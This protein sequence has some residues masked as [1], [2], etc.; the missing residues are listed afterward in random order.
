VTPTWQNRAACI[1]HT[2]ELFFAPEHEYPRAKDRRIAQAKVI[3]GGCPVRAECLA[4]AEAHDEKHGIWGGLT[5]MERGAAQTRSKAKKTVSYVHG[6][7]G[8]AGGHRNR[9][10]DPCEVC[11]LA[12]NAYMLAYNKAKKAQRRAS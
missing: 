10:E 11:R 9:G 8:G 4:Y 1:G 5:E 2:G 3:C 6:T 7:R 12:E